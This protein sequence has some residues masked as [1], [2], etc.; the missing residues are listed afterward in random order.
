[1]KKKMLASAITTA[2]LLLILSCTT[3]P[4]PII[5]SISVNTDLVKTEYYQGQVFDLSGLKVYANYSN[6]SQKEVKDYETSIQDGSELLESGNLLIKIFYSGNIAEFN[7]TVIPLI[8]TRI[9]FNVEKIKKEYYLSESF[10]LSGL[11]V[12]EYYNDGSSQN[13]TNF[14]TSL[15]D[16]ASF[17]VSGKI[18]VIIT[19]SGEYTSFDIDVYDVAITDIVLNTENVKKEYFQNET[20][21]LS[22]LIVIA[23]YNDG[24]KKIINDYSVY[25]TKESSFE[26]VGKTIITI[27]YD[28]KVSTFEI[29]IIETSVIDIVLNTDNIKKKCYQ[30]DSLDLS[31]LIV[32]ANYNDGSQKEITDFKTS[33]LNKTDN[34]T[35]T[36]TYENKSKSFTI[37]VIGISYVQINTE[38]IKEYYFQGEY[39]DLSGLVVL[40]TYIDGLEKEVTD[41]TTSIE[42]GTELKESGYIPVIV[43]YADKET[44]FLI[45]VTELLITNIELDTKNTKTEYYE[46]EF[47]DLTGLLV[48]AKY[49]D[50]SVKEI[51]DYSISMENGSELKES[52]KIKISITYDNKTADFYIN[53]VKNNFSSITITIPEYND[54]QNLLS[55]E[56]GVYTAISGYESYKWM[57][58]GIL[59]NI[60]ENSYSP[61]IN[62]LQAGYH[63]LLLIVETISGKSYSATASFL[64]QK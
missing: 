53:V 10:D 5:T 43:S 29:N 27:S 13:I 64:I 3:E 2:F 16:G 40:A 25:P 50:D 62:L 36:V 48:F 24:S 54:I 45:Y 42:N 49:N 26:T 23:N 12:T 15:E 35:V 57:I 1:M 20:L 18:C 59:L 46:N 22:G 11:V 37:D 33:I 9:G 47:L 52:G 34:I 44:V 21:D 39:F 19:Y 31:G 28:N 4:E 17:T 51:T 61:D 30:G 8:V 14:D 63:E 56:N 60:T 6:G 55:E 32:T 58:D 7:I 38:N 41:Y